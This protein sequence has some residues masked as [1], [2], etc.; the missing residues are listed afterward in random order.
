MDYGS[1]TIQERFREDNLASVKAVEAI[2]ESIV[3]K[4]VV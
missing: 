4:G 3:E 2:C 1:Q